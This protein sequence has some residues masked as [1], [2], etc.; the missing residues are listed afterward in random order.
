MDHETRPQTLQFTLPTFPHLFI[1]WMN[2]SCNVWEWVLV[3]VDF[4][5]IFYLFLLRL[6]RLVQERQKGGLLFLPHLLDLLHPS[7]TVVQYGK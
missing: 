6:L 7:L 3:G 4:N 2:E 5:L 1:L